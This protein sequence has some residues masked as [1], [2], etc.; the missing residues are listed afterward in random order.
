MKK[1]F[2]FF[3]LLSSIASVDPTYTNLACNTLS[4]S[5]AFISFFGTQTGIRPSFVTYS[6]SGLFASVVNNGDNSV[7]VYA[8]NSTNGA[9]D[10]VET[11]DTENLPSFLAY[12]PNDTY[13]AVT[14]SASNSISI[15][16][17]SSKTGR[18]TLIQ[19][20]NSSD[21]SE[22]RTPYSVSYSPDGRFAAVTNIGNASIAV[23]KIHPLHGLWNYVQ[24]V[25]TPFRGSLV[26]TYSPDG[27]F[28]AVSNSL[29]NSISIYSVD[30]VTG[31]FTEVGS[32]FPTGSSAPLDVVYSHGGDFL[33]VTCPDTPAVI[34]YRVQPKT[35]VLT[36]PVVTVTKGAHPQFIAFSKDD[37]LLAVTDI[38][39]SGTANDG[40]VEIFCVDAQNGTLAENETIVDL[41]APY[42]VDFA[43]SARAAAVTLFN[44]NSVNVY[45]VGESSAACP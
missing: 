28:A 5:P 6:H 31:F 12:S 24:T 15:Y 19:T 32:P 1:I 43:P 9:F 7:S 29:Q 40:K 27:N 26:V 13:A 10:L 45:R 4:A 30:P 16:G 35:G 39:T 3:S 33:A 8:V 23:Y 11:V 22:I 42:G 44:A 18:F 21:N 17:V 14:N 2:C 38:G 37:A 36:D 25:S 34:L 20:L 41:P